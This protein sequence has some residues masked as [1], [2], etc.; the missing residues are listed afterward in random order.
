MPEIQPIKYDYFEGADDEFVF[1]P[2]AAGLEIVEIALSA[3]AKE[4]H[5]DL[6]GYRRLVLFDDGQQ[7]CEKRFFTFDACDQG[8]VSGDKLLA[9]DVLT[10]A[11]YPSHPEVACQHHDVQFIVIRTDGFT[12]AASCHL[13]HN[14][15]YAGFSL[16]ARMEPIGKQEIPCP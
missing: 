11:R 10:A 5:I 1:P 13:E 3:D 4:I 15:A 12:V 7:C 6:R 9:V 2:E 8:L 16:R 14:G